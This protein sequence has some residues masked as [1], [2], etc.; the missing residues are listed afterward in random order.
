[1]HQFITGVIQIF[2][3]NVL[4]LEDLCFVHPSQFHVLFFLFFH[5]NLNIS[6]INF[7]SI[8]IRL[9]YFM[10]KGSARRTSSDLCATRNKTLM[11]MSCQNRSRTCIPLRTDSI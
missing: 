11:R 9:L 5:A 1:M 8:F 6:P 4:A 3:A 10:T 7:Q 2:A